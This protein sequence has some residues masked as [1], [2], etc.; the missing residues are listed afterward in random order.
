MPNP[1]DNNSRFPY[2]PASPVIGGPRFHVT[3]DAIYVLH[4]DGVLRKWDLIGEIV[5]DFNIP[6]E[7]KE[8]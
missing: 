8:T 3:E 7:Y 5:P 4:D 6:L 2:L 1:L